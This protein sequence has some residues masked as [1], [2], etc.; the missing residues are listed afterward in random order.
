MNSMGTTLALVAS[1]AIDASITVL[2]HGDAI[3]LA[4]VL[5]NLNHLDRPC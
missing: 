4:G 1:K 2:N 5:R 3:R